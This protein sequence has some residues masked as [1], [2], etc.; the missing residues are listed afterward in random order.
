M[1]GKIIGAAVRL[2]AV[3]VATLVL[4]AFQP[5]YAD[6]AS[7]TPGDGQ[8]TPA[9]LPGSGDRPVN[10]M[11]RGG[12]RTGTK[13]RTKTGTGA[14]GT[15]TGTATTTGTVTGAANTPTGTATTTGTATGAAG[16][17]TGTATTTGTVTGAT[18]TAT[19]TATEGD[20]VDED[21]AVQQTTVA[22]V[23]TAPVTTEQLAAQAELGAHQEAAVHGQQMPPAAGAVQGQADVGGQMA[24]QPAALPIG[25]SQLPSTATSAAGQLIAIIGVGAAAMYAAL[26]HRR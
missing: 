14:A 19:N 6:A 23:Q 17:A 3:S 7:D 4:F 10:D 24:T 16:T 12:T 26:R 20:T 25:L 2:M 22:G 13:T 9:Q 8:Q 21:V 5:A 1:R 11:T 15:A 18:A